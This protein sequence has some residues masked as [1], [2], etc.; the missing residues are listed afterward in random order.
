MKLFCKNQG[1]VS[2]FLVIIL[3]PVL[4]VTSLFVDASRMMLAKSV[5]SSAGDL[6]LNSMMTQYDTNLN[7]FYG[8]LASSQNINEFEDTVKTYFRHSMESRDI[9]KE[10]IDEVMETVGGMLDP[11]GVSEDSISDLLQITVDENSLTAKPIANSGLDNPAV[12]KTQIINF[13][14]YRAPIDGVSALIDRFT[15]V[16][17]K[18]KNKTQEA[19]LIAAKEEAAEAEGDLM[20]VVKKLYDACKKYTT[21]VKS[22]DPSA[23]NEREALQN[24][25]NYCK[26]C[27]GKYKQIH[28]S[29]VCNLL[30]VSALNRDISKFIPYRA[31][32]YPGKKFHSLHK[33]SEGD[34]TD[35]VMNL[36]N[37]VVMFREREDEV[38]KIIQELDDK[39]SGRNEILR[40]ISYG[41]KIGDAYKSWIDT[42][43]DVSRF[44]EQLSQAVSHTDINV[45]ENGVKLEITCENGDKYTKT[46][47]YQKIAEGMDKLY[48]T[49][50]ND[51]GTGLKSDIYRKMLN[52][53]S[54]Y[55]V[56]SHK[57]ETL[58]KNERRRINQEIKS[59]SNQL[60]RYYKILE[61]VDKK[62]GD[63]LNRISK[64]RA[65][66]DGFDTTKEEWRR[67]A[68]SAQDNGIKLGASEIELMNDT[69]PKS[70]GELL[71]EIGE[72]ITNENIAGMRSRLQDLRSQVNGLK[73]GLDS[74][75][76][77]N[78]K[79][80]DISDV[81]TVLLVLENSGLFTMEEIENGTSDALEQKAKSIFGQMYTEFSHG[82][83]EWL[84]SEE[85]APVLEEPGECSRTKLYRFMKSQ[86]GEINEE[87]YKKGEKEYKDYKGQ[88][89]KAVE[90][91]KDSS[92]EVEALDDIFK[93]SSK[94]I[95]ESKGASSLPSELWGKE[96]SMGSIGAT[97]DSKANKK[98]MQVKDA[99]D[100]LKSIFGVLANALKSIRD[101]VYAIDYIQ[102]M[103][104]CD[105]TVKEDLYDMAKKDEE[106]DVST[107]AKALKSQKEEV[108]SYNST[109]ITNHYNRSMT[110]Q[111]ICN[112][113]NVCMGNEIEYILY[114]GKNAS[115]KAKA[116]GT[117]FTIRF[118][119]NAIYG[120]TNLY[121][122][123]GADDFDALAIEGAAAGISAA[124]LGVIPI[125][126]V[127]IALILAV[128]MAESLSDIVYMKNG[129]PVALIKTDDTWN[130][131][132]SNIVEGKIEDEVK[133]QAEGKKKGDDD[134]AFQYSDYL[135]FFLLVSMI[136]E[137]EYTIYSRVAD[138]IQ[139]NMQPLSQDFAMDKAKTWFCVSAQVQVKPLML[140]LP[141][142]ANYMSQEHISQDFSGWGKMNYQ[143]SNGYY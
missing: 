65:K 44:R 66:K 131:S 34:I 48:R 49:V 80:R 63:I 81:S 60:K 104:T 137:H 46:G 95:K 78:E 13:M 124:T 37:A 83:T 85:A 38:K 54:H 43:V 129:L 6:A 7:K 92:G 115:N 31:K 28:I 90:N 82:D 45:E 70:E 138:V 76:Y 67:Q 123:H 39:D 30:Y 121:T 3:V 99:A 74:M 55:S 8:L 9:E 21:S 93:N 103:F 51:N 136:G 42:A 143:M 114:G 108:D 27:K 127:K 15:K 73:V 2:V 71:K 106:E 14:K 98:N 111:L 1:V 141:I 117:I 79:V 29:V 132:A 87:N 33:A 18:T 112:E 89:D 86:F 94:E 40:D 105:T 97:E 125:P 57:I 32:P 50:W 53:V 128:V 102:N 22:A 41:K 113:N 19:E 23:S 118:A 4:T 130:T 56:D 134:L 142:N 88:K 110:N 5:V 72:N 135:N 52:N 10:A 16:V 26:D 119:F 62:I 68:K 133:K 109:D 11:S 122:P 61:D 96:H 36:Q 116:W 69:S 64:L 75:K 107:L 35:L 101:D 59:I 140:H 58:I 25:I 100:S 77:G 120:F 20:E 24:M 12:V 91:E 84:G 17:E 139:V 47:S 126:L